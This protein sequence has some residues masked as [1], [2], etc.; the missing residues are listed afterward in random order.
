MTP[1]QIGG[2]I[3]TVGFPAV[4]AGFLVRWM[5]QRFDGKLDRLAD[6]VEANSRVTGE[7][8]TEIRSQARSHRGTP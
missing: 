6:A 7:L 5:T 1:E 8:V 4:I 2:L 3:G